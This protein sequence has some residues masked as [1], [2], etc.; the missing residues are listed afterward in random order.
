[1]NVNIH[2]F[3]IHPENFEQIVLGSKRHEVRKDDRAQRPRAGDLIVLREWRPDFKEEPRR[4]KDDEPP[5]VPTCGEYTG[6]EIQKRVTYVTEPGT[7][8]LP[9]N[10][11][12]MSI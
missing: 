4:R 6:R 1:M 7:W 5:A 8:G 11:Y 3:K 12:V 2:H 9:E 10:I